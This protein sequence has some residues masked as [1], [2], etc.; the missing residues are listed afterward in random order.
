MTNINRHNYEVFFIDYLEG[1]LSVVQEKELM[2]FLEKNPD[3]KKELQD[4]EEINISPSYEKI[5]PDKSVLRKDNAVLPEEKPFDEQCIA[6]IEGDLNQNEEKLFDQIIQ[7]DIDKEK[8][9]RIYQKTKVTPDYTIKYPEKKYLKAKSEKTKKV[10]SL[11]LQ[12][13]LATAASITLIIGLFFNNSSK[14]TGKYNQYADIQHIQ[15]KSTFRKATKNNNELNIN[16]KNTKNL[17]DLNIDFNKILSVNEVKDLSY[18]TSTNNSIQK[19]HPITISELKTDKQLYA[20]NIVNKE[21]LNQDFQNSERNNSHTPILSIKTSDPKLTPLTKINKNTGFSLLDIAD[22]G[23][24]GISKLT[25]KE[26]SLERTYKN[27][28]ELKHLA[29]KTESFSISTK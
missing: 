7:D 3:L 16:I 15:T 18:V 27:N 14:T 24:K 25:G 2:M 6:K 17:K 29:F 8:V 9:F 28:G 22:L 13:I 5:F 10:I 26:I 19:L 12:T 4:W 21:S 1:N 23:F 11:N 20:T